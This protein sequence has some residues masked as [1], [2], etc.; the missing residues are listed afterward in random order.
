MDLA[1][2]KKKTLIREL[3]PGKKRKYKER[4]MNDIGI[5]G[6]GLMTDSDEDNSCIRDESDDLNEFLEE[7]VVVKNIEK[8]HSILKKSIMF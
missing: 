8:I 3:R 1:R 6:K 5:W 4:K 2:K 7:Q